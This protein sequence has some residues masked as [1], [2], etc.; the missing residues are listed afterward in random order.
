[1]FG[2]F[3]LIGLLFVILFNLLLFYV[4]KGAIKEALLELKTFDSCEK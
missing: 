1:M 2:L 3:I 4:V